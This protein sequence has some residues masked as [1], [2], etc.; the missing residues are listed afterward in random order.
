MLLGEMNFSELIDYN[1]LCAVAD[2]RYSRIASCAQAATRRSPR[3]AVLG[4]TSH[5]VDRLARES[6]KIY[7]IRLTLLRNC[8]D[9]PFVIDNR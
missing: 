3:R 8:L 4:N 1:G 9:F 6:L 5:S 7:I 2:Q